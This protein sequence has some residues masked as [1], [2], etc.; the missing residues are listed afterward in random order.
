MGLGSVVS[1]LLGNKGAKKAAHSA[2]V[3]QRK[4]MQE[5]SDAYG[6]ITGN[7]NYYL[8]QAQQGWNNYVSTINGDLNGF[9][10]SPFGQF[11]N[12]YVMNNTINRL[13]GT[14]AARGNML[15]GNT[16]KELQTNIQSILSSDYLDRLGRY[17]GYNQSLGSTALGITDALNQYRW[18]QAAANAGAQ[19]E[20][21]N[22]NSAQQLAKYNNLGN[23]WSGLIDS[24][25]NLAAGLTSGSLSRGLSALATDGSSL[26]NK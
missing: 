22:I 1:G 3:A 23:L 20:I 4:A 11:Y 13:Q 16:L 2:R 14:A 10:A 15:S 24:G 25:I 17:L 21:G 9:N 6:D 19:Q 5:Y 8:P 18:N 12:D 7:Y 26:V